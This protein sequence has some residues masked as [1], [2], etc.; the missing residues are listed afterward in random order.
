MAVGLNIRFSILITSLLFS[1]VEDGHKSHDDLFNVLVFHQDGEAQGVLLQLADVVLCYVFHDVSSGLFMKI[2][3]F[4]V[5]SRFSM[6]DSLSSF[7]K[8]RMSRK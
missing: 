6:M 3:S 4:W 1:F 5:S 2:S 8:N 7:L